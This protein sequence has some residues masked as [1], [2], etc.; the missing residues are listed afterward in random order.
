MM[1]QYDYST[2]RYN[3]GILRL[4]V[5]DMIKTIVQY[6]VLFCATV[7]AVHLYSYVGKWM[8]ILLIAALASTLIAY[9]F[10]PAGDREGTL[11]DIR[12]NLFLYDLV[13]IGGFYLISNW[14]QIDGTL[15][16]VSFGLASG[17]VM[18]NTIAGYL[19]I[20][21]QMIIIVSPITHFFYEIKRI[22][23]Y[24]KKGYGGVTK[25]QRMEQLQRNI[26]K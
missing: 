26:V 13:A 22:M 5:W 17:T 11:A 6:L 9:I 1:I 12:R 2:P 10:V 3:T 20:I 15:L 24:H 4:E 19:P 21:L 16:G 7:Y 25:R 8:I 14:A 18:G 23:T